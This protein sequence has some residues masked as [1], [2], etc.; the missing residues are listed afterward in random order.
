M[1]HTAEYLRNWHRKRMSDPKVREQVLDKRSSVFKERYA[2]DPEFRARTRAAANQYRHRH[3]IQYTANYYRKNAKARGIVWLLT[4]EQVEAVVHC[5]CAYCGALPSPRNGIDRIDN[6]L[7][8]TP[9]NV[10][11]C[12][13]TC[14]R[15]KADMNMAQFISWIDRLSKRMLNV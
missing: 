14:N 15:A 11:A 9:D 10:T 7:G 12:C 8:Y 3:P 5:E 4:V 13:L 2:N 6:S 1:T